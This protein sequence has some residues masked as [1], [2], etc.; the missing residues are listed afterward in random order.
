MPFD[1]KT[2]IYNSKYT[3]DLFYYFIAFV[4]TLYGIIRQIL[5]TFEI[6]ETEE[7]ILGVFTRIA[8]NDILI[9]T[10]V[11]NTVGPAH[12]TRRGTRS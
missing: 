12:C 10:H 1:L 8:R 3:M 11:V 4:T 2:N 9:K 6:I 7:T 5:N